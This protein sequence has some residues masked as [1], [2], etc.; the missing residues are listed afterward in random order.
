MRRLLVPL[1]AAAAALVPLTGTASATTLPQV[2]R[3]SCYLEVESSASSCV[4]VLDRSNP[5]EVDLFVDDGTGSLTISCASG[6]S[7]SASGGYGTYW[8]QWYHGTV[9]V[10]QFTVTALA[11]VSAG[12][13]G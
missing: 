9:D 4:V 5:S 13:V 2:A 7:W 10:C 1:A 11:G 6:F 3:G 12:Y 8:E